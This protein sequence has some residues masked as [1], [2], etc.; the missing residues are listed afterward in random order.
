M[1][2]LTLMM[3]SIVRSCF[4]RYW[5]FAGDDDDADDHYDQKIS[6]QSWKLS[7]ICRIF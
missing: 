6:R 3:L 7:G 2:L 4:D 5:L 1:R